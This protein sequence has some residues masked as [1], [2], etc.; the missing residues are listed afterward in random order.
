MTAVL[1]TAV[2]DEIID[3][4]VVPSAE[5]ARQIAQDREDSQLPEGEDYYPLDWEIDVR[6]S[7]SVERVTIDD[8]YYEVWPA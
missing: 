5:Q 3:V 7:K 2:D 6:G 8:L 4:Q 1:I